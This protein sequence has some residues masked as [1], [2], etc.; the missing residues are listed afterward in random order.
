MPSVPD[1]SDARIQGQETFNFVWLFPIVLIV[2][3]E[4]EH[5]RFDTHHLTNRTRADCSQQVSLSQR[6]WLWFV[7]LNPSAELLI[8][9]ERNVT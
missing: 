7:R 3:I 4:S 9:G 2:V 8:S 1:N 5:V 6:S